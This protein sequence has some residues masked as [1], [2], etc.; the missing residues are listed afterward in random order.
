MFPIVAALMIAVPLLFDVGLQATTGKDTADYLVD[1]LTAL[2]VIDPIN[3]A[4][5]G[6]TA[7]V[8]DY[9]FEFLVTEVPGMQ[10]GEFLSLT[11]LQLLL[12]LAVLVLAVA[13]AHPKDRRRVRA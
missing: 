10:F 11:W 4:A 3:V 5:S 9:V 13:A 2:G 8:G 6:G 12:I 1:G 7:D